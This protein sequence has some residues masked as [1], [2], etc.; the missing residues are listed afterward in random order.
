MSLQIRPP[1]PRSSET[2]DLQAGGSRT[3][4]WAAWDPG[5]RPRGQGPSARAARTATR[6][7][8]LPEGAADMPDQDIC[9][10]PVIVTLPGQI[11][12]ANAEQPAG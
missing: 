2:G 4:A 5:P 3:P 7:L 12:T 9:A 10:Q 8:P 11:T 1:A 6:S